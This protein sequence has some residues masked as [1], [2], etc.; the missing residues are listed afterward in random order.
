MKNVVMVKVV[1]P[2]IKKAQVDFIQGRPGIYRA[3]VKV[4]AGWNVTV[5]DIGIQNKWGRKNWNS[6]LDVFKN[7][8]KGALQSIEF[9]PEGHDHWLTV[10]ARSGN[11]IKL[12]DTAMLCEIKVGD[13]NQDWSRTNLYN[14]AQYSAV[15]AETWDDLAYAMN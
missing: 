15:N 6:A 2:E 11:K 5:E 14:M 8:Q 9:Q 10:F 3:I 1:S 12:I 13:I 4:S 7:F